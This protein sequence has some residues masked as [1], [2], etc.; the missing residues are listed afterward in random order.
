MGFDL[1]HPVIEH[2]L[3]PSVIKPLV[4]EE[5]ARLWIDQNAAIK[6]PANKQR[7]AF[8]PAYRQ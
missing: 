3:T 1:P 7:N 4:I 6:N 2:A 8:C 5:R